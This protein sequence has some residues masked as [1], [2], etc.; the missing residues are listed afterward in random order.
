MTKLTSYVLFASLPA[1]L[2]AASVFGDLP[3][4]FEANQGQLSNPEIQFVSRGPGYALAL[5]SGSARF[6][7]GGQEVTMAL[8]GAWQRVPGRGEAPLPTLSNYMVGTDRA[9]W[10]TGISNY[11]R[12]RFAGVYPRVDLVYYGSGKELEYDFVVAPGG[13]PQQI[14][15]RFAGAERARID[16]ATGDLVLRMPNGEARQKRPVLY[17]ES[18]DGKRVMVAGGYRKMG[19]SRIGFSVGAYDRVRPLVIDPVL[20]F[21]TLF[22]GQIRESASAIALDPQGN[23][24]VAGVSASPDF[25]R[26]A[27]VPQGRHVGANDV[28]VAKLN[29]RGTAVLYATQI[30]GG[31]EEFGVSLSVDRFGNAFVSGSTRSA[32]FPTTSGSYRE[33]SSGTPGDGDGFV[34]KLNATGTA[35]LYSTRIGGRGNDSVNAVAVDNNNGQ[36]VLTGQTA[37]NDY[38]ITSRD[39][40]QTE[41]KGSDDAFIT[42][43]NDTGTGLIFST[44]LGGDSQ[45]FIVGTEAG[46]AIAIDRVGAI[47]VAGY[48]TLRDFPIT[49]NAAQSQHLGDADVFVSKVSGDGKA[50]L[51]S[52][53]LGGEGQDIVNGIYIEPTGTNIYVVG[54]TTSARFPVT[55]GT[56]QNFIFGGQPFPRDGFVT[57]INANGHLV[58][59]T[60]LGGN[61]DDQLN[62]I[63]GDDAGNAYA[64]GTTSSTNMP[65]SVT[66]IQTNP[67]RGQ[68][69]EPY[70]AFIVA[71]N[72]VGTQYLWTTYLGGLRNEEGNGITRDG[73]GNLYVAGYTQSSGFPVTPNSL[74]N[75]SAF[76]NTAFIARIGEQ[77]GSASQLVQFSGNQQRGDQSTIL[78]QPLVVEL[79]DEFNVPIVN[80]PVDFTISSGVLSSNRVFTNGAGRASVSVT[81]PD[82]PGVVT[83]TA[84]AGGT[85][86]AV[87]FELTS[88][89]VGPPLPEISA[90]GVVSAGLSSPPQQMLATNSIATIFGIRFAAP[91]TNAVA[92]QSTFV[93]GK[94]PTQLGGTCVTV[95]GVA[96]R[97]LAVTESQVNF[98]VPELMRTGQLPVQVL[99]NCGRVTELKS[100]AVNVEI[101]P[102]APE[103]FYAANTPGARASVSMVDAATGAT[104]NAA[105][106]G[107]IVSIFGT[108]FGPT[109]PPVGTGEL[110]TGI[111]RTAEPAI[112]TFD[113]RPLNG[114]GS[115]LYAGV[116]PGLAGVYQL[117]L[118]IP[119]N[120][121]NGNLTLGVRFGQQSSPAGSFIR[122][123][124]GENRDPQVA[125]S[126]SR[127]EFGDVLI[128][129]R[130]DLP[131]TIANSGTSVLTVRAFDA[132]L[133]VFTIK[134]TFGFELD[135]GET[136]VLTVSFM[137]QTAGPINATL[138]V[139]TDDPVDSVVSVPIS[140]VGFVQPPPPSPKPELTRIN[141]NNVTA[142][143]APFNLALFGT[144]FVRGSVVQ[145]NGRARSTFFANDRQLI[146]FIEAGDIID[147]GSVE[148]AV[149]NPSPGG[150]TSN[151]L[152]LSITGT[153]PSNAP[154]GLINQIDLKFCPAITS[155][156]SVLDSTGTPVRNITR[157][158]LSCRDGS[159]TV[160]CTIQPASVDSPLSLHLVFGLNGIVTEAEQS[161]L[162]SAA[163]QLIQALGPQD[164][165]AITHLEDVSRLQLNFTHDTNRALRV[166]D[167]LRAVPPGNALYDS[168]VSAAESTRQHPGKRRIIVLMT[169]LDNL[170]GVLRDLNQALGT[171]RSSGVTFYTIAT[172]PGKTDTGLTGFLRTLARDTG[173]QFFSEDV[174]TNYSGLVNRLAQIIQSQHEIKHE[175]L[176]F[177]TVT[178][179]LQFIFRLPEGDVTAVRNY[180][181]CL[182]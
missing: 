118:Q 150:G 134:P 33:R 66:S 3:L 89:R 167:S 25:P 43:L 155:Y 45:G 176:F 163:R 35:L 72:S 87:R 44:L 42:K 175:A 131:F 77:R 31:D 132:G 47:Y 156:V 130:R 58:Y 67:S 18:A 127:I 61:G 137:P 78:T 153:T 157:E 182:P 30:G 62:A 109:N 37:S 57:K 5:T 170:S 145:A 148:I 73:A 13:D 82:R 117:N 99:S 91:G 36:V 83:V 143:G 48:T 126:P 79:R 34:F 160:D 147:P 172:G 64:I 85:I 104:L 164:Q 7:A 20:Q 11:Q 26:T 56:L 46:K 52:T 106:P 21:A 123:E 135:P 159:D 158:R 171:A 76:G 141:P 149:V 174:P 161:Q 81:L 112:V 144:G 71:I 70:D 9:Q 74:R 24:Y 1:A 110:P 124:G 138:R 93:A 165:I 28:F 54:G 115:V 23:V 102:T 152:P 177:N 41:R 32:N 59:S 142:G 125:V 151:A 90:G 65:T 107:Q 154:L 29:P 136:R 98:I 97:L 39:V 95:D 16:A 103:F 19:G 101:R 63:V 119:P 100:D 180:T 166:I 14:A 40:L 146:A 173:G 111:A 113:G 140:G 75:P 122:I 108:G 162:K 8:D 139:A 27:G 92:D 38:P 17:Q 51:Y 80:Q 179:P 116:A 55:P 181:P 15:F 68:V 86:P 169:S 10:R 120:A 4:R 128:G 60:F 22:G 6:L 121:R 88:L 129:Q 49:P 94:V 105:R 53:Y 114:G 178:R 133:P 168:V 69:G 2:Q 84:S 50:L 96:A 12:V